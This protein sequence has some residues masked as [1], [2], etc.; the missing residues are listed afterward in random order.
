[1]SFQPP[2]TTVQGY[3]VHNARISYIS[4]RAQGIQALALWKGDDSYPSSERWLRQE[5]GMA[6]QQM[7]CL[8]LD[9]A[10]AAEML[11]LTAEMWVMTIGFG[12][13]EDLDRERVRDGFRQL[14]RKLKKWPQP[15]ELTDVL[16]G[17]PKRTAL[18][19][20]EISPVDHAEQSRRLQDIMNM[21]NNG[22]SDHGKQE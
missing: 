20:P 7:I 2:Q 14:Y 9:G 4:R 16:P 3:P 21:L 22:G 12:M 10:P 11:P 1:M 8:A 18:M 17:R 6:F 5:I 19:E 15:V 13:V